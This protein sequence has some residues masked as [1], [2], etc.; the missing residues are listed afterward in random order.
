MHGRLFARLRPLLVALLF[1][2]LAAACSPT[3]APSPSAASDPVAPSP[4]AGDATPAELAAIEFRRTYG[5]RAALE[6]VRAVASNPRSTDDEFGVPLTPEELLGIRVRGDSENVGRVAFERAEAYPDDYCGSYMDHD[7][8][9]PLVSMWRDNLDGHR[10]AILFQVGPDA[11]VG[12]V[13]CTYAKTYLD[14]IQNQ[15]G[16][17]LDWL[18]E[19]P[20]EALELGSHTKENRM[21]MAIS[22]AARG[23]AERVRQHY[24]TALDLPAGLLT[25]TSDGTGATLVPWGAVD[26]TIVGPDGPFGEREILRYE[27]SPG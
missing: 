27:L 17:D 11:N 7:N 14:R 8:G 19:I 9:G 10:A 15:I 18:A 3:V 20:A 1:V 26:V 13:G 5:L 4:T 24:E 25:V 12:F 21:F 23:A 6:H 16:H 22:S 2:A